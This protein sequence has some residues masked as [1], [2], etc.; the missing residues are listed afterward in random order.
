L[1]LF[2]ELSTLGKQLAHTLLLCQGRGGVGS[3]LPLR[4]LERRQSFAGPGST[5]V[6]DIFHRPLLKTPNLFSAE[7][8]E[9]SG[10][11]SSKTF[12]SIDYRSNYYFG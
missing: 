6:D 3:M 8:R 2:Q 11:V 5:T 1:H 9:H 10:F 4:P 7:N 12:R